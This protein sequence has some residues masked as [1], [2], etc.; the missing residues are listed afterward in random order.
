MPKTWEEIAK[1]DPIGEVYRDWE[2]GPYRIR[3]M[4]GPSS[5]NAYIGVKPGH[6]LYGKSYTDIDS[7]IDCHCGLTFSGEGDGERW[8]SGYWWFGWDYA[9]GLDAC[10]YYLSYPQLETPDCIRWTP[11]MIAAEIPEAIKSFNI[12]TAAHDVPMVK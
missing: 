8:P 2:E 4:R 7:E 6:V 9:H 10:F 1:N 3:I 12:A 11:E 5:V